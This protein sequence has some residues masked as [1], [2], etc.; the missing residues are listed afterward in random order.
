MYSNHMIERFKQWYVGLVHRN[1]FKKRQVISY[2]VTY[3]TFHQFRKKNWEP[4]Y[5][6]MK[7]ILCGF[8]YR[9]PG[10]IFIILFLLLYLYI[11]IFIITPNCYNK[12]ILMLWYFA[13]GYISNTCVDIDYE[14]VKRKLLQSRKI[15]TSPLPP[16]PP[17]PPHMLN[18]ETNN[19]D[20]Y[21]RSC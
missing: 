1:I 14:A 9:C 21:G 20:R 8:I 10:I 15:D 13:D 6:N 7:M 5:L 12:V 18:M 2:A 3:L 11:F 19:R 17:D 4:R 16:P